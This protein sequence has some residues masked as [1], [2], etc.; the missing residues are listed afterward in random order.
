MAVA[1]T[2]IAVILAVL[3]AQLAIRACERRD[4]ASLAFLLPLWRNC[5]ESVLS[6]AGRGA[7]PSRK[8]IVND[9]TMTA[10]AAVQMEPHA[11]GQD[12]AQLVCSPETIEMALL[13]PKCCW[14]CAV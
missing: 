10:A 14:R 6:L 8:C 4:A 9:S 1:A 7:P 11:D 12:N 3:H 5:T 2:I 13:L